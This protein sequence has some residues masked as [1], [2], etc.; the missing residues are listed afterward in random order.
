[1]GSQRFGTL[2]SHACIACLT[3]ILFGIEGWRVVYQL[4][5][6]V[7]VLAGVL[8]FYFGSDPRPTLHNGAR[9]QNGSLWS[10][11]IAIFKL[12]TFQVII[13]QGI[14]GSMCVT[15]RTLPP[16][17]LAELEVLLSDGRSSSS[18]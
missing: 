12:R 3:R 8:V 10:E 6:L 4:V 16:L 1:M 13:A 15:Q 11:A 17:N 18:H 9:G 7:S 2:L 14:V 5:G